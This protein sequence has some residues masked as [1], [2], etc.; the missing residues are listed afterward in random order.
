MD[1]LLEIDDA[2]RRF[3]P[4]RPMRR[5]GSI[6]ASAAT[7]ANTRSMVSNGKTNDEARSAASP[8]PLTFPHAPLLG[9]Q[10]RELA[11]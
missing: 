11:S 4:Q 6:T 1:V 8:R 10:R 5:T 7:S 3:P 9:A 2:P